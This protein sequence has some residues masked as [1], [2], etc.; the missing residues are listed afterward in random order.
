MASAARTELSSQPPNQLKLSMERNSSP[1]SKHF[2]LIHGKHGI[3]IYIFHC[4][5]YKAYM[6]YTIYTLSVVYTLYM[7]Y[8]IYALYMVYTILTL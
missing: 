2:W 1:Q 5:M 3:Q 6:V 7:V 4:Q 8:T